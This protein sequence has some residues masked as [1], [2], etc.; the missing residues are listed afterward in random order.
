MSRDAAFDLH[1]HSNCSDGSLP[2]G[3]L[4]QRAAAAGVLVLALTDHDT[5]AGIEEAQGAAGQSEFG[6][7]RAN[8]A[9]SNP[10]PVG[11]RS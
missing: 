2:P 7:A 4:V 6:Q 10:P 5:I 1:T 3:E 9:H 11:L 8:L